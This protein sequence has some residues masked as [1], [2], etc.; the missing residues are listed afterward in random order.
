VQHPSSGTDDDGAL[1]LE[2]AAPNY[3]RNAAAVN[4]QDIL[5]CSISS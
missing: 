4:A 1:G 5:C 2:A 3:H